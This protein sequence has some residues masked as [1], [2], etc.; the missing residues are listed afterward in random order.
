MQENFKLA[1]TFGWQVQVYELSFAGM[2]L[3]FESSSVL[4][5]HVIG[6]ELLEDWRVIYR[7]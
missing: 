7:K 2:E 6:Q 5:C 1:A 3:D 4:I